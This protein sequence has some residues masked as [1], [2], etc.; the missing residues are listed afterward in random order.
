MDVLTIS[1]RE[2]NKGLKVT[3]VIVEGV[4]TGRIL[5]P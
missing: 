4:F 1:R 3:F 2:E 5:S